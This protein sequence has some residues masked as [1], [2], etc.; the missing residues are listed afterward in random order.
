MMVHFVPTL[1]PAMEELEAC[2]RLGA[3]ASHEQLVSA[4]R[5][6]RERGLVVRAPEKVAQVAERLLARRSLS[7]EETFVVT[8]QL[9]EA[10]CRVPTAANLARADELLMTLGTR[11]QQ[12]QRVTRLLSLIDEAGGRDED[13]VAAIEMV[14]EI[15]GSNMIAS[16]RMAAVASGAGEKAAVEALNEHLKTFGG[17]ATAWIQLGE[18]HMFGGRFRLAAFCFSE[19]VLI[20]PA[21]YHLHCRVGECL[22]S[23]SLEGDAPKK[24]G[25]SSKKTSTAVVKETEPDEDPMCLQARRHLAH[26]AR[27]SRGRHP[28]TLLLLEA[29]CARVACDEAALV[30]SVS[31]RDGPLPMSDAEALTR[32]KEANAAISKWAAES[33][34][35]ALT[36]TS[37]M[38]AAVLHVS[39]LMADEASTSPES[40]ASAGLKASAH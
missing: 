10:L 36:G 15:N 33:L 2:C 9:A 27:L 5:L 22:L 14:R 4:L 29:A 30:A 32:G 12:S 28:R 39:E 35:K 18:L 23:A 31:G 1:S 25:E 17:D 26:A 21:M 24:R 6:V 20:Q 19:A 13:A 7:E 34:A 37:P 16:R 11:F 40:A 38:N 3:S 8:E